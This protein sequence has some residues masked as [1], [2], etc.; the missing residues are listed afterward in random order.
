MGGAGAKFWSEVRG[1]D[2]CLVL[3]RCYCC[4]CMYSSSRVL[5]VLLSIIEEL[6]ML[7]AEGCLLFRPPYFAA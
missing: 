6:I 5:C 4:R 2:M 7:L 1:R 3:P